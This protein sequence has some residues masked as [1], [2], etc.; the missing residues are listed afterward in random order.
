MIMKDFSQR[1][2]VEILEIAR[3]AL[4][5]VF[6]EIAEELDL[7]DDYLVE[8]RDRIITATDNPKT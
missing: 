5:M 6:T 2:Q 3:V 4:A 1:E 7:S 8:L